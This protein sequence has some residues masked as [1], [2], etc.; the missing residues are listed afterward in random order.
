MIFSSMPFPKYS[1]EYAGKYSY[2]TCIY[3]KV[4]IGAQRLINLEIPEAR[5]LNILGTS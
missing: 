3:D 4:M 5:F 2:A 1:L